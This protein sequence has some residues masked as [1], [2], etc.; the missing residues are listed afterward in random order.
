MQPFSRSSVYWWMS[1]VFRIIVGAPNAQT[2]QQNVE[3]GGAVYRCH[4]EQQHCE[5]IPFDVQG[6]RQRCSLTR[7]P[8]VTWEERVALAQ[9]CNKVPISYN[10]IWDAT[11][12]PRNSFLPFVNHHP[13]LIHPSLD[14]PH[15]PSKTASGSYQ[16][17]CHSTLSGLTDR[18]THRPTDGL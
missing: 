9:L 15:S 18:H 16:P 8:E 5:P 14:R 6:E 4:V 3:H 10:G 2:N 1:S 12:S 13:H 11:N 17:F 7:N